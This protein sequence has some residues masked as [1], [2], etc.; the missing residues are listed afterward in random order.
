[1]FVLKRFRRR[2]LAEGGE[3]LGRLE[4]AFVDEA[5]VERA[6]KADEAGVRF[7]LRVVIR[8]VSPADERPDETVEAEK[9]VLVESLYQ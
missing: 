1:M 5:V 7:I 8:T 3:T 6:D 4:Y 9:D 2:N